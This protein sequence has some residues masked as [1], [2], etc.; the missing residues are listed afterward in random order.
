[1]IPGLE[2]L[3][4]ESGVDI[5]LGAH[6]HSYE[7]TW[8]IYDLQVLNGSN[9]SPYTDS[10]G[11]VHI[12]TGSA[13]CRE[14]HTRF[15]PTPP[16]FSA[17]RSTDYGFTRM[18]VFNR[19]HVHFEQ[20]S[21]DQDYAV[22]DSVWV[23][24][25]QPGRPVWSWSISEGKKMVVKSILYSA[26]PS[27][28]NLAET[29]CLIIGHLN[30]LRNAVPFDAVKV[31]L[32]DFVAPDLYR[33]A[34]DK[35]N[36]GT[37]ADIIPLYLNKAAV[38][39]LPTKCSRHNAPSQPHAF[40]NVLKGWNPPEAPVGDVSESHIVI[41]C[42]PQDVLSLGCA[43]ARAFPLYSAKTGS[44]FAV[45]AVQD[46]ANLLPTTP[47][48]NTRTTAD[49]KESRV[50]VE[51]I[52]IP[53]ISAS[54]EFAVDRAIVRRSLDT[55]S[56]L[57]DG[58]R[59]AA[60]IVDTPPNLMTTTALVKEAQQVAQQ[61]GAE[62]LVIKGEELR[63]RGF[64]ALYSVGK[65]SVEPPYLVV[66][67]HRPK[68]SQG[69]KLKKIA[70]VGKGITFDTGGLCIKT[71]KNLM[72]GMKRD[73]GG[74]AGVLGA[75]QAAVRSGFDQELYAV[76]CIAENSISADATRPDDIIYSYSGKSIEINNTDAEGR[77]VLADGVAYAQKDLRC[78]V[79]IDMA[80]LTGAQGIATGR[81]HAAIVTNN[82]YYEFLAY[83]M[84]KI[85]GDLNF[86]LVYA[87]EL[88]FSEFHSAVADMK[89]SVANRDNATSSC[90]GLFIQSHL[91]FDWPG[92]WVHIDMAS[93]VHAGERATGFG[94]ALLAGL[95]ANYS[96]SPLL[97]GLPQ[98]ADIADKFSMV[99]TPDFSGP[100]TRESGIN[101]AIRPPL[102]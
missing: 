27:S 1:M 74:A 54:E 29:P 73:C 3:F 20:V 62:I 84:G 89:N 60:R 52:V 43:V 7:R 93:P 91:G 30:L 83:R 4:H 36:P 12:I 45:K 11:I 46:S 95:C 39:A 10:K 50:I 42:F 26:E 98:I 102:Q 32:G 16:D 57:A 101:D 96:E 47:N 64:G 18:T 78:E 79:I 63:D 97:R 66:L 22:I 44:V 86:P 33:E 21:D 77:L 2:D 38:A 56:Y 48:R 28:S 90:A 81:Y 15:N 17:F 23:Q 49:T 19:T 94:V 71:P 5:V 100:L 88:H 61:V 59:L 65:A 55:I 9:D 25:T 69:K 53:N 82:E 76:L 70:W 67:S 68:D 99:S 41:V 14:N 8:P 34:V 24:K 35:L 58:I 40:Y 92:V 37:T 75:F 87:P 31:K 80:T 51:F 13:G 85:T 72:C 6:E